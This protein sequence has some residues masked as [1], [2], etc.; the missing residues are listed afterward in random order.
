[1]SQFASLLAHGVLG[2]VLCGAAIGLGRRFLSLD[3]TLLVHAVIAPLA[4]G[5]LSWHHFGRFPSVSPLRTALGLFGVVVTL[6][7]FESGN[8]VRDRS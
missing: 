3:A 1:M 8:A 2:W 5:L 6:D 4:F 7:S